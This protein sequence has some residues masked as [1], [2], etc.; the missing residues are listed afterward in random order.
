MRIG[1]PKEI[2]TNEARVGLVPSAV[3]ELT[4]RGHEVLVETDA[5]LGSGMT[6][7]DYEAAGARIVPTADEVWSA[8]EMIVKVKEPQAA[9]RRKLS[10]GQVLFTY[11]HLAPDPEQTADLVASGATCIAYETVTSPYGGLPLLAPMSEVPDGLPR[12]W[13]PIAWNGHK[14]A[15]ASCSAVCQACPRQRSSSWAVVFPAHM[16]QRSPWAWVP[17]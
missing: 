1:V 4:R 13:A 16:R 5:G 7:A 3:A 9:E 14:A 8:A 6:N 17:M 12:K 11:L 2:K 10:K 15:V